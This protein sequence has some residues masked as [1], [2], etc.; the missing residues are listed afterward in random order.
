MTSKIIQSNQ[1][2]SKELREFG[3]VTGAITLLLFVLLLPLLFNHGL[4]IW[5]WIVAAVLCVWALLLPASLLPL[6]RGWIAIGHL[7]GWINTRIILGILFYFLFLPVGVV[8][9]LLGKDPM[10]R[11]IDKTLKTY[12]VKHVQPKKNHVERPY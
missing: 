9:K 2:S 5:P 7:L 6:Y 10:A 3:L 12:R 1:P 8:L 4:P 11:K